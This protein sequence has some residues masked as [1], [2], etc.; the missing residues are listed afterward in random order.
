MGEPRIGRGRE[1]S[2]GSGGVEKGG[3]GT[4]IGVPR[5]VGR[6][7]VVELLGGVGGIGGALVGGGGGGVV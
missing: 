5:G 1:A 2:E 4:R 7:G 3:S 6:V